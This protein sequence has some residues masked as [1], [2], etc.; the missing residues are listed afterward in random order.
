MAAKVIGPNI[1]GFLSTVKSEIYR[2]A[3]TVHENMKLRIR[4]VLQQIMRFHQ[5]SLRTIF[6]R[7]SEN[8]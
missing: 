5:R 1:I 4:E 8:V 6:C 7:N 3:G 2:T